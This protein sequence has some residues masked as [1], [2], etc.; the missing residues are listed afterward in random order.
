MNTTVP[1]QIE[2]IIDVAN[3]LLTTGTTGASTSEVIAA[4]FML[5]RMEFI[6]DGYSVIEAWERL[7]YRWQR[8]VKEARNHYSHLLVPW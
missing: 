2:K 5:N 7:D 4:A 8:Y 6:P 1:W 3:E